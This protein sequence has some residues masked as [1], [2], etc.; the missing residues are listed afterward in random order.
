[1][2]VPRWSL[3]GDW[4]DVC[5]CNI[6][7]P[8]TFAQTP[9][10]GDC[11]G[12]LAYHIKKGLY[13]EIPLDGL[14]VLALADFKGNIWAGNTKANIAVFFDNRADEKQRDSLKM[15]FTGKAGG[16]M[17][18]FAKL[19][20]EVRGVDFAP[21]KFEISEDLAYWSVEIPGKVIAKGE[22][23]TGP[24]TPPG[25]RVQT[26]NP[27]GSEVGPGAVVTWGRAVTDEVNVPEYRYEWKRSGR[28]SKHIVF[29]WTGP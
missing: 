18:E 19:I 10:Y 15:I 22:A 6:P 14:N 25:K 13:G 23:L 20:G 26:I 29:N 24:M 4:F 27:P 17:A 1:M 21:I 11:D 3:S 8:C 7:C 2:N 9:S 12:V 16:F 5:K 28:S